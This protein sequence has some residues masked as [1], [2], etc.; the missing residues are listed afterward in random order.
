M[1]PFL[2]HPGPI[3]FA[4]RGGAA[5]WPENTMEAFASA[6]E[7]GYRY[8]E[9]DVH[10]TQDGVLVAFHDDRLERITD[11]AGRIAA[12]PWAE[13]ARARVA[14]RHRIVRLAELLD[15]WPDVRVNI[16]PKDDRAVGPLID[17]LRDRRVLERVCIGAF[18][19]ARL[20]AIRAAFGPRICTAL[21]PREVALLRA[22]SWTG[23]AGIRAARFGLRP[24]GSA[25]VQIPTRS[26]RLRLADAALLR[27]AGRLGLPVHIWTVNDP[28]EMRRLL[29]LGVAGLMTDLPAV[30]RD[31]LVER[32][33]W[34]PRSAA[35]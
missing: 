30:L 4:H 11:A 12:L 10:A 33:E 9:T 35:D 13:V 31:V 20:A 8:L 27:A 28:S 5:S 16:D 19:D 3:A 26:G 17:V 22:A 34:H 25:C 24:S 18:G 15:A 6:V 32:G 7:L 2:D 23:G 21:G 1:H 14:G 29:D